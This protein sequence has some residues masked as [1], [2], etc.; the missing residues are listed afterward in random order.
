MT[1]SENREDPA[2]RR[3]RGLAV[4]AV[5][6]AARAG[7]LTCL[8]AVAGAVTFALSPTWTP[9]VTFSNTSGAHGG[10]FGNGK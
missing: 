10:Y 4:A 6:V 2:G 8:V 3:R 1:E 5:S 7:A 9:V